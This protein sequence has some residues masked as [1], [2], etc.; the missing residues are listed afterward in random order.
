MGLNN[1]LRNRWPERHKEMPKY[2][3]IG[4][5]VLVAVYYLTVEWLPLGTHKGTGINFLFVGGLIGVILAILMTMVHFYEKILRWC[6]DNKVKFLMIPVFTVLFGFVIW[7]GFGKSFG[8]VRS[9]LDTIGMDIS[10][11]A[12]WKAGTKAFP[13]VG[14]EFMPALDEGSFLLMP[15][16]M[17]HAGIERNLEYVQQLDKRLTTIPEVDVAV[18]KWGRV[19][20]ALDPAPVQ[21]FEN[22]INYRSEFILNENGHRMK[23]KVDRDDN[24]VLKDGTTYNWQKEEF[25]LIPRENLIPDE[26]G[27]Y[28]RQWR[29]HIKSPDDIWNEIVKV[30]NLPD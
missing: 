18:G 25:R 3:N 17:P 23:F 2:V 21:M 9:G 4:L 30:T 26:R 15:T 6:L 8:F 11:T 19:N 1:L 12:V 29:P 13:G 28:F 14:K 7:L 10:R 24:F 27:E 5:T 20:S 22:T 16:S